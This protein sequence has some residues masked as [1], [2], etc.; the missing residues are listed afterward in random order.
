MSDFAQQGPIITLPCLTTAC[1]DALDREILP[2][3]TR[4]FPVALVIPCIAADAVQPPLSQI[5][6][7]LHDVRW[8]Q[9]VIIP[10]NGLPHGEFE[11]I[12]QNL[13][14][15]HFRLPLT[16]LHT[17]TDLPELSPG[18]GTNV[19]NALRLLKLN[20]FNGIVSILDADNLA[21]QKDNLARL[22]HPVVDRS[23]GIEF[24]K[25][26]YSRFDEQLHGRVSRLFLAPLLDAL[27]SALPG[28]LT[29]FL[30]AFRYP[31]AGECALTMRLAEQTQLPSGWGLEI[32]LLAEAHRLLSPD[33]VCQIESPHPH[34]HRHHSDQQHLI[35]QCRAILGTLAAHPSTENRLSNT[36]LSSLQPLLAQAQLRALRA[37]SL[38]ARAN[39]LLHDVDHEF[40]LC[41]LFAHT[42]A[43][44]LKPGLFTGIS[45]L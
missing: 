24:A 26:F 30:N 3:L 12:A 39:G 44:P 18:K 17:D 6:T 2:H 25:H 28:D 11:R 4:K 34:Q 22:V 32:A 20:A 10:I 9:H 31:L 42:L 36:F 33:A 21:F 45:D 27:S 15:S 40:E 8:L 7:T 29:R 38:I 19:L 37:S 43:E 16:A 5:L 23:F 35:Q 13:L 14:K 1:A 41:R